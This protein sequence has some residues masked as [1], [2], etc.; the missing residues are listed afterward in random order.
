MRVDKD[1]PAER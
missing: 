1:T